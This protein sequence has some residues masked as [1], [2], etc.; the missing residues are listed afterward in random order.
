MILS[1]Y[2]TEVRSLVHDDAAVDFTD[3]QLTNYINNARNAVAIDFSCVTQFIT[4][5]NFIALQETYSYDGS[6]GGAALVAGGA[7]YVAPIVSVALPPAGGT[8]AT[9]V[10]TQTGGVVTG[11]AMTNWGRGYASVPAFTITDAGPGTGATATGIGIFNAFNVLFINAIWGNQRYQLKFRGFTLFNAYHRA[12]LLYYQRPATFSLAPPMMKTVYVQPVPDQVYTT[13]WTV[14]TLPNPLVNPT[15]IDSQVLQPQAD[16][17]QY[18]AAFL[19]LMKLQNFGQADYMMKLYD[20]RVPRIITGA[21]GIRIPNP[22]NKSFQRR[23]A[24]G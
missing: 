7:N 2:L 11:I 3:A 16:A 15:D 20:R 5:L 13:E 12:Q 23:I 9:A 21:G 8:R 6:I 17:V 14:T 22:Y 18:Y 19:A 1:D 4:G 10:A 24:R